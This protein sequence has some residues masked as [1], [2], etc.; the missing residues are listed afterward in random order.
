[1]TLTIRPVI[2]S[3]LPEADRI[4]R[5]AFG[6]FVG[7]PNPET[8][9]GD[10]N[11]IETRWRANPA[12]SLA[13]VEGGRLMGTNFI[14]RWGSFGFF[15]PL[16]VHP[17]FWDRGIGKALLGPT[18]EIMESWKLRQM[19][20]FTFAQS[21][22]H[23]SLYGKYGFRPRYLAAV[24]LKKVGE[25]PSKPPK[26]RE[27]SKLKDSA[28]AEFLRECKEITD[29]NYSGLDVA[30]EIVSVHAQSLGETLLLQYGGGLAVCHIGKGTEAG[31]GV[32][33]VKFGA[34]APGKNALKDFGR[35]LDA[36]EA[37]AVAGGAKVVLAGVNTARTAAFDAMLARGYRIQ[38]QGI[39]MHRPSK[40]GF[41][42]P[43]SMV[44]D[45]WR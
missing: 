15:G 24:M 20:L 38:S 22:K 8:F 12:A 36:I 11:W 25:K 30:S 6:T 16:S 17:E 18:M 45:D 29:A 43:N 3:D 34:A 2:E 21:A 7:M 4:F 23:V 1:M 14:A 27:F 31:S 32:C 42:K 9:A 28:R 26:F 10:T 5:T 44:I 19:A 33:Y 13:A 37:Y 39:T 40:P 35:L 41:C